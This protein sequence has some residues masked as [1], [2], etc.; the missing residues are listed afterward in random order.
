MATHEEKTR[1]M[2]SPAGSA[3]SAKKRAGDTPNLAEA[4]V[5]L[6][7]VRCLVSCNNPVRKAKLH[8]G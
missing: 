3:A 8:H 5:S 2:R 4:K 6:R 1:L 7:M